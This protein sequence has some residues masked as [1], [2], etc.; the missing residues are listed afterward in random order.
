VTISP[1]QIYEQIKGATFALDKLTSKERE[2]LPGGQFAENYN[3]LLDLAKESMPT[4]D[5]RRWPPHVE[6][7]RAA[8]AES[9]S[10]ARYVEIYAYY[11]QI[12]AILSESLETPPAGF[13]G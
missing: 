3:T 5:S 8:M 7:R 13:L 9:R 11:K 4:A 10:T 2:E 1:D 6:T 12:M